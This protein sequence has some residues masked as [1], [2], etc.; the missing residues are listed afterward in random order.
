MSVTCRCCELAPVVC[1]I[2]ANGLEQIYCED[3]VAAVVQ[4]HNNVYVMNET[5]PAD[6]ALLD[7]TERH[8]QRLVDNGEWKP[9]EKK[10]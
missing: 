1:Q 3:C 5:D 8:L 9:E 7:Q 10:E 4:A 2:S 6:L